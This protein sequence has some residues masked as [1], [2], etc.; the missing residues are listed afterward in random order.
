VRPSFDNSC[1]VDLETRDKHEVRQWFRFD[2]ERNKEITE[3]D[4]IRHLLNAGTQQLKTLQNS[5]VLIVKD[6][7]FKPIS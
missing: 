1:G 5:V 3:K 2:I 7:N 6:P 4:H